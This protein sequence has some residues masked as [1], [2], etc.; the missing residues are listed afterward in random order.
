MKKLSLLLLVVPFFLLGQEDANHL[1][2]LTHIKVKMGHEAQ[3][4]EGVKMYKKCYAENGGEDKWNFWRRIQGKG[5]VY[6]VTS[7][8][9]NWAELDEERDD[10]S[11]KC[12]SV[13]PS[14]LAPHMEESYRAIT[15]FMPDISNNSTDPA[16]KVWVTYFKVKNSADFMAVVKAVSGQIKKV[17]G[18]ERA[19]WYAFEGGSKEA[20]DYLV[21]WPFDKYADLDKDMDGV[22]KIY[23]NEHGK[24][25]TEQLRAKFRNAVDDAWGYIYDKNDAMSKKD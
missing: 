12:R 5:T 16:S 13:F 15:S 11:K 7:M 2:N 21:A 6:A 8:M 25:K 23:E 20:P 24:K 14:F 17:E 3:F 18:D 19:Y 10:A 9:D 1:S 22:W 4:I